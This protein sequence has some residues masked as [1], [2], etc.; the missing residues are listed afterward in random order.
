[1]QARHAPAVYPAFETAP[2]RADSLVPATTTTTTTTRDQLAAEA[3]AA[4]TMN[5]LVP[6]AAVAAVAA[7]AEPAP[8]ARIEDAPVHLTRLGLTPEHNVELAFYGDAERVLLPSA[9]VGP[10]ASAEDAADA[11][12]FTDEIVEASAAGLPTLAMQ[13]AE[14]T[15]DFHGSRS[16]FLVST[17]SR[18][19]VNL[20]GKRIEYKGV[21]YLCLLPPLVSRKADTNARARDE[22]GMEYIGVCLEPTKRKHHA[23]RLLEDASGKH[24]ELLTKVAV[25]R[26]FGAFLEAGG[27]ALRETI[28]ESKNARAASFVAPL[29]KFGLHIAYS[30]LPYVPDSMMA[31]LAREHKEAVK[32]AAAA[33]KAAAA[34]AESSSSSSSSSSAAASAMS[35]GVL[36]AVRGAGGGAA[37]ESVFATD[38]KA[39]ARAHD[40]FANALAFV[41]ELSPLQC[42]ENGELWQSKASAPAAAAA[43]KPASKKRRAPA[44]AA[45]AAASPPPPASRAKVARTRRVVLEL[46]AEGRALADT[47]LVTRDSFLAHVLA[48][49]EALLGVEPPRS[50]FADG[51]L[52]FAQFVA[53][54]EARARA[55]VFVDELY[56]LMPSIV[57]LDAAADDDD[58]DDDDDASTVL[59][60]DTTAW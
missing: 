45:A 18:A 12:D 36:A 3:P 11:L 9:D 8:L 7:A 32:A 21:S 54:A 47:D 51:T 28:V 35:P 34:A 26:A 31:R 5:P 46:P 57:C 44:A 23:F 37:A 1:M 39:G 56:A 30:S 22:P 40:S 6:A 43:K 19:T 49:P 10:S 2:P 38:A 13:E 55:R 53:N 27:A 16:A 60:V 52:T 48:K 33:A 29:F 24:V 41:S 17:L 15:G 50:G 14:P 59:P 25:E 4:T 20:V 58:D 42:A